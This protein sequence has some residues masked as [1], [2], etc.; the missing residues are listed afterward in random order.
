MPQRVR[1]SGQDVQSGSLTFLIFFTMCVCVCVHIHA[2]MCTRV[3]CEFNPL[4]VGSDVL[5]FTNFNPPPDSSDSTNMTV[6]HPTII[7]QLAFAT[8]RDKRLLFLTILW[9]RWSSSLGAGW[10]EMASF[11]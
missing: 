6:M 11:T 8:L 1:K 5:D 3:V 7:Y 4:P 2:R 10:P 9:V